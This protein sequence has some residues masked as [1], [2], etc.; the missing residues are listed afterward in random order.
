MAFSAPLKV[1][2]AG[3]LAMEA[4]VQNQNGAQE[5]ADTRDRR[6]GFGER[7]KIVNSKLAIGICHTFLF[8][9]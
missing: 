8:L 7:A 5:F 6:G 4:L 1:L 9:T 3:I 2:V